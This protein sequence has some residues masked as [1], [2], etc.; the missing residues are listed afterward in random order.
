MR[1][2]RLAAALLGGTMLCCAQGARASCPSP[3]PNLSGPPFVDGCALPAAALNRL[4][5]LN[6]P[7]FTGSLSAQGANITGNET[8]SGTLGVGTT[9]MSGQE[10]IKVGAD[11]YETLVNGDLWLTQNA[12]YDG[13]HW[14][15]VNTAL[16]SYGWN[17]NVH[18]NIPGETS[19]T[20]PV[21]WTAA[22]G[23]NPISST[24]GSAGGWDLGL[25]STQFKDLVI[26]GYGVEMDGNGTLPYGRTVNN[27]YSSEGQRVG[28]VWNLYDN[29]GGVDQNTSP[30]WYF[31]TLG[32]SWVVQRAAAGQTTAA[33]LSSLISVDN[34]GILHTGQGVLLP[35][36]TVSA[37]PTC[38][39]AAKGWLY[40]VSDATAPTYNGALTGG[41]AVSVPVYCNGTSW[42]SH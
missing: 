13:T 2:S 24:F 35:L 9:A 4:A 7:F 26:G 3:N 39:S 37:L 10:S 21:L 28:M 12:Y 11:V 6:F 33:G 27:N 34:G 14:Q 20:G 5:P 31:G 15:R 32:D 38:N 18:N 29:L 22:A 40:A 1:F 42:T 36:T 23:S 30:S 25:A 19:T 16:T 41:G 17:Y 8:I